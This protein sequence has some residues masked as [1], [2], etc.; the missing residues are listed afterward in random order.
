MRLH[1]FVASAL[2]EAGHE[3]SLHLTTR[4][5]GEARSAGWSPDAVSGLRVEHHGGTLSPHL[6]ESGFDH[7][8][9]D[10]TK[11]PNPVVRH[12][13][14]RFESQVDKFYEQVLHEKLRGIL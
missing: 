14:N 3:A 2:E 4:M 13:E 1:A 8:Y 12:Y 11:P 9:G 5:Q 6:P 7:E 10:D